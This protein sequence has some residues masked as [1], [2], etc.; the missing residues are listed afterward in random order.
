MFLKRLELVGFKSFADRTELEFVP[1]VTAVV[2][3]NGSGKSNIS[4]AIR[5]VLGEQSAKSLRGGKMEDII[6]VGSDSRKPVNFA[7][8]SLTLDNTDRTLPVEYSEVTVTRRVYRSGESEYYINKR[9]CR[10]KDIMELFMDTG[11]GKEAYSIIGQGRIEEILST[12]AEDRRGIF[13]EAAGIVKYKNRKREAERKLEDTTQNLVRIH[14]IVS[15]IDQQIGPLEEQAEK[16]KRYNELREQLTGHEVSLY[17][18]QIEATHEKWEASRQMVDKLKEEHLVLSAEAS[19]QEAKLTE[20]RVQAN[21]LDQSIEELQQALLKVSEDVEKA[22]GQREVLKE[23]LRNLASNRK[24]TLEQ[25]HRIGEKQRLLDQQ[26]ADEQRKTEETRQRVQEAEEQLALAEAEFQAIHQALA[27]DVESLKSDY[28]D[29]LNELANVRNDIRHLQQLIQTQS[30]RAERLSQDREKW[31]EEQKQAADKLV[32]WEQE[33]KRL[34]KE[35]EDTLGKYRETQEKSKE[36]QAEYDRIRRELQAAEQQRSAALSRLEWIKEMQTEFAGFQQGVKEI[37]KAR[38]KGF[39]GIH[40]AVAELIKVPEHVETA[41]EVALGGALQNVVVD[42]E[43]AGREAIAYLKQHNLGRATFL[44]LD[45]IRS[46]RL[47]DADRAIIEKQEGVVGIASELVSFAET[48]RGIVESLLGTV[49][50]TRTL[51]QAN[52]VARSSGYRYRIVT[53]DG[54]LVNAGGSMTGGALKKN[55][56]QLLGRNRQ[57]EELEVQAA[58]AEKSI[59]KLQERLEHLQGE[60]KQAM[61][62]LERLRSEG[63]MLRVKEQEAKGQMGQAQAEAKGIAERLFLLEQDLDGYRREIEEAER[64]LSEQ[65]ETLSRL[66][67]EEKQLAEAVAIAENRRQSQLSDKEEMNERITSLKVA[68]AQARQELQSRE[69]QLERLREQKEALQQEWE[70]ENKTLQELDELEQSNEASTGEWEQKVQKLRQDKDRVANIIAERRNERNQLSVE[71]ERIEHETREIRKKAKQV[72]DVLHAEEVKSNRYDVELDHLLSKLSEEYQMSYEWAKEKY[73]PTKE[74]AE[75]QQIVTR[76]KKEMAD[77][78]TVNL[79]AIEEYERLSE[80]LSFLRKQEADL[81]EA[82]EMLYQVIHEMDT[83]MAKRFQQTFE[84]I[85]EQFRDVFVQLF[86]G[87]RADLLLTNPDNLL[88]TGVDIVAQPPGKKLQNLALLSGGERAFTA[89]ALLFAILRVKPVP[90]CV[91][92]EVEA[93]LD[94][95]NVVRFA[96]YMRHFSSQTQFICVTHRKG[97]MER[98]D[99]LYGVTMQEGGVSKLVSVKLEDTKTLVGN[100]S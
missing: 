38:E 59:R 15:E 31:L 97:T 68:V 96:E 29:K 86:G 46:R 44:P 73:P 57:A 2:G 93:A 71:L 63:E 42:D 78:G 39:K 9:A 36:W 95:A 85:R 89:M 56:S 41:V 77:L 79:G 14:D 47:P 17:V 26:L 10:L 49:I 50:I 28:F 45:V 88:E 35:I 72:E 19:A 5:W 48:Y 33:Q 34:E 70:E 99:V 53:L 12:K 87:G 16:A 67:G 32:H 7:E 40:G 80:R 18:Q 30:I 43:K 58:E 4:D 20:V 84:E 64:K 94:E 81:N 62:E 74:M 60:M 65:T 22:E 90:F 91:L 8:V 24:Q 83:E 51:E 27:E 37:L 61:E 52:K 21:D 25:L 55:T 98:A 92:D 6:F 66:E 82:K 100:V 69:E 54:D 75:L 76:L 1:G 23:R 3:P 11:V 13:E